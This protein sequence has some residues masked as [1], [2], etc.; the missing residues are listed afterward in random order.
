M[1]RDVQ[2]KYIQHSITDSSVEQI[3]KIQQDIW[4]CKHT[5]ILKLYVAI[6]SVRYRKII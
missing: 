2:I 5:K 1:L 6:T 4:T 3:N